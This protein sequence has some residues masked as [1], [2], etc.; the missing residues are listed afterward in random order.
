MTALCQSTKAFKNKT[1]KPFENCSQKESY[2]IVKQLL[3]NAQE[4]KLLVSKCD[5][6]YTMTKTKNGELKE[7]YQK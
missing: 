3:S 5:K 4:K 6:L 7:L 2:T 1:F